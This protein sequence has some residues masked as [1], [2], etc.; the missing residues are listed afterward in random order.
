M[1]GI[2]DKPDTGGIPYCAAPAEP[3]RKI[4]IG[5]QRC[6]TQNKNGVKCKM[7]TV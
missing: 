2:P 6:K 4:R 7:K 1:P 5:R 3:R